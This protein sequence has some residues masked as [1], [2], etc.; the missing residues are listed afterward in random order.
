[1]FFWMSD[2]A[3]ERVESAFERR[4]TEV[5]REMDAASL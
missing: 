1:M 3:R 4:E 5:A 2:F